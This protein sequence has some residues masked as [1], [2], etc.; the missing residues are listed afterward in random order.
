[1]PYATDRT[2]YCALQ[3]NAG[4][5]GGGYAGLQAQGGWSGGDFP[6]HVH[7]A[8]W[9]SQLVPDP[10]EVEHLAEGAVAEPFGG[11]GNG[12]KVLWP[13]FWPTG[14]PLRLVVSAD[15]GADGESTLFALR[16]EEADGAWTHVATLRYPVTGVRFG[17]SNGS[18]L[19]DFGATAGA[20]R[21]FATG[22]RY[23]QRDDLTWHADD[24]AT[25]SVNGSQGQHDGGVAGGRFFLETGGDSE[26]TIGNGTPLTVPFQPATPDLPAWAPTAFDAQFACPGDAVFSWELGA[27]AGLQARAEI[28][29][30]DNPEFAGEPLLAGGFTGSQTTLALPCP[31]LPGG[32]LWS[33]LVVEDVFGRVADPLSTEDVVAV[34]DPAPRPGGLALQAWPNPFN[35]ALR[36]ATELPAAGPLELRVVDLRGALVH[37]ESR[38][39]APAGALELAWTPRGLPSGLYLLRLSAA[40]GVATEKALLLQ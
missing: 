30:H 38:A 36:I 15:D 32:A 34:G 11:E 23:W 3:W 2:Y 14:L 22:N 40:G 5:E 26:P 29:V 25:F 21:R 20:I 6:R 16:A 35:G 19:E 12:M 39:W 28:A 10:I 4:L 1:V 24:A 17:G 18:F 13:L 9:E 8:L 33:R 37:R 31:G 27:A 7:F